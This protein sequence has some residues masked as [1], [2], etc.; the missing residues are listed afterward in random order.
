MMNR[1][2]SSSSST[3]IRNAGGSAASTRNPTAITTPRRELVASRGIVV[4]G[5]ISK[6]HTNNNNNNNTPQGEVV[7]PNLREVSVEK[8]SPS[9]IREVRQVVDPQLLQTLNACLEEVR[10][11]DFRNAELERSL[12]KAEAR[13]V[14][15]STELDTTK[16]ALTAK[17]AVEETNLKLQAKLLSLERSKFGDGEISREILEQERQAFA[18]LQKQYTILDSYYNE[19]LV[20][21]QESEKEKKEDLT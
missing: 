19:L 5:R 7:S 9:R 13:V 16:R 11:V 1:S 10:K 4:S 18:E 2:R 21:V 3:P 17:V 12:K 6:P 20:Y 14:E 8:K 15:L